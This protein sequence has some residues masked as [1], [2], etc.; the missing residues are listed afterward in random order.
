MS[1]VVDV[2]VVDDLLVVSDDHWLYPSIWILD[3]A[4]PHHY[5]LNRSWFSTYTKIEEGSV[6]LEDDH[7][8]KVAGIENVRVRMFDGIVRTLTNVKHV[9]KLK[10]NL[11]SLGY[12]E[13]QGYV[14]GG[15]PGSGCLR[16]TK[17]SLVI[18]KGRRM[19]NNLYQM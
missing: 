5:T 7:P 16:I 12:L 9:P 13:R 6:T 4:C 14:F 10:K 2:E 8:C 3:S 18:M 1:A 15:Q 19:E 11:I 17:G